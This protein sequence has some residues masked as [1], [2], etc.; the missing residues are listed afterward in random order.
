MTPGVESQ[1]G[2]PQ[3]R[4]IWD[5]LVFLQWHSFRNR[6]V[7]R[8]KRLKQPKYLVGAVFGGM[9]FYFYFFRYFFGMRVGR[10]GLSLGRTPEQTLFFE[11]LGGLILFTIVLL[12]WIIPHERAALAFSEAE[13]SFL[14]PAP[15]RRRDLI[16]FKLVRSQIAILF[17]IFF[18]TIV[19]ARFFTGHALFRVLGWWLILSF[20]NLHMMGSSFARTMLLDKGIGNWTRRALVLALA[21]I[22]AVAVVLW[23][24]RTIPGFEWDSTSMGG[25]R[26]YADQVFNSGPGLYLL[27]PF[28]LVVRPYLAQSAGEFLT[29]SLPV[30]LFIGLEYWWVARS[31]VAFEEGS[32]EASR[33]LAERVTAMRS[34]QWRGSR[35][36]LKSRR[37]PFRLGP[38]GP[39]LF[40]LVW[41]NLIGAGSVFTARAWLIMVVLGVG[42]SLF[43]RRGNPA[44][45]LGVGVF[46]GA[47]VLWVLLLGPQILRQDFRKDLPMADLLKTYPLPAW[48]IAA[49]EVLP[50]VIILAAMQYLMLLISFT[51]LFRGPGLGNWLG[52][53]EQISVMVSAG[54]LLPV[55]DAIVLQIPNSA[56]LLFPG[57]FQ[58]GKDAPQGVEATGQRLFFMVGQL[59]I[60]VAALI[61]PGA[62]AVGVFL[63]A[64][65][66]LG[67]AL[68]MF[69][70]A[71]SAALLLAVEAGMG[72]VLLGRLFDRLDVTER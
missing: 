69:A 56:V 45:A 48:Q 36:K 5:A 14:F 50:P 46:L 37:A 54:L 23:V 21:A 4:G 63:L 13:V 32:I 65:L 53:P 43:F 71:F 67:L 7:M 19:T 30:L 42:L 31:D 33:K 20:L 11:C 64:R 38:D 68:S 62:M 24:R 3:A 61:I 44:A 35:T 12:A 15:V 66:G 72:F 47:M 41:K 49:G 18:L 55:L 25:L 60:L 8:F 70:A 6:I 58:T 22:G 16:H 34:G 1:T 57:W 28:R 27:F 39:R 59:V 17:T 26:Q 51:L 9:Y 10:S 40:A 52:V 2:G 29:A